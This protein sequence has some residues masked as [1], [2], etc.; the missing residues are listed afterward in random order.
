MAKQGE[1][2]IKLGLFVLAGLLVMMVAF[3][4]IGKNR[5]IFG[6]DFELKVRFAN[7][8]GLMEGNNVLFSGIQAGTVKSIRMVNDT[9]IEV[10][11]QIDSKVKPFIHKNALAAIGTEGLM[12][13]KVINITPIN[14]AS[15]PVNSGD[16]LA[17][18]KMV[19]TDEMLQTLSKTNSNIARISEALKSTVLR[20]DSSAIF[21]VLND[22]T[23]GIS[24]RSS[25]HNIDKASRN[26][27]DLTAGLNE[28][29]VRI[30]QGKGTAG[31]LLSDTALAANLK[32]ALIKLKSASE[33][34]DQLTRQA[35]TMVTSV[36]NDLNNGKGTLHAL[37][38]DSL[39]AKK[40]SITL[41]NVMKGTD[42]FNQNMEALKHN[43]LFKG[44]FK[45]QEKKK[46]AA[47]KALSN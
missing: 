40:I 22:K 4:M 47:A 13:N 35:N 3:Y 11:M 1:N 28:L 36:N 27:N 19:S 37:L 20:L 23:I 8:N 44:F 45:D 31:L 41:D 34:A 26:A 7:L 30:K 14:L 33:N 25:L 24:L 10:A 42:G 9:T 21:D 17:V 6:S 16:E 46:S 32:L 29:V 43:F 18:Q 39:I 12:G 38:K 5:N 15:E 2:N